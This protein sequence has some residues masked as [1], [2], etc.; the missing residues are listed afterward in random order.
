MKKQLAIFALLLVF[1]SLIGLRVF[2]CGIAGES[3]AAMF[4]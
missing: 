3:A 2:A 1:V 4:I